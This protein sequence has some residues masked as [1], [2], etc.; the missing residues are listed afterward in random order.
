MI[1]G[2]SNYDSDRIALLKR[3]AD[4]IWEV[5]DDAAIIFE[6]L[7]VNSEERELANYG[8]KLWGN[9]NYNYNEATNGLP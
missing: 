9:Q 6:H 5:K 3:M 2:E 1:H 8:I 4:K 7:A